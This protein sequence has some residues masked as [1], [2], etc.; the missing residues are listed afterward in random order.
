[1]EYNQTME[2]KIFEKQSN[3]N[4]RT[5]YEYERKLML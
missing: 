5:E 3:P 1:M 2:R 4:W